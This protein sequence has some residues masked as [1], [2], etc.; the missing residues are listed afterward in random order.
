MNRINAATGAKISIYHNFNDEVAFHRQHWWRC[1]G[2]CRERPP[3]FGYV[4]RATNRAP[5]PN[6]RWHQEHQLTCGGEF[7]KIKEP[8]GYS[9]K[10]QTKSGATSG[11]DDKTA[12]KPIKKP[13]ADP[14]PGDGHVLGES[15]GGKMRRLD[16]YFQPVGK[17]KTES[18]NKSENNSQ[19]AC[20][21]C[22]NLVQES[23]MNEHL[24]ECLTK[25]MLNDEGGQAAAF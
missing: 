17:T 10:K 13:A 3:F 15:S 18:K 23:E 4:K 14:F 12:K 20:P 1:R 5:G 8:E 24:D 7:E 19:T 16:E 25:S 22:Q 2:P 9:S 11:K 21:V 6:D